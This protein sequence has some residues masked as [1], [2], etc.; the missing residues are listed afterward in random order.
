[1][2]QKLTLRELTDIAWDRETG[3]KMRL[4]LVGNSSSSESAAEGIYL[5]TEAGE[6][7]HIV[8]EN[9]FRIS[10]IDETTG[11]GSHENPFR[12]IDES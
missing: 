3:R 2:P 4:S 6:S 9:G 11:D 10:R 5:S 7:F 12:S 1:M 8:A